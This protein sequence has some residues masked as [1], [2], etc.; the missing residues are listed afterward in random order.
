M[1]HDLKID[2]D[3]H[4]RGGALQRV[5]G[6]IERRGFDIVAMLAP[7]REP[8][9]RRTVELCVDGGDRDPHG[10]ARQLDKLFDV[11]RAEVVGRRSLDV[12]RG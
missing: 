4:H 11:H 3:P 10:L 12:A 9:R 1:Y 2:L 6:V 5:L 7:P 8:R